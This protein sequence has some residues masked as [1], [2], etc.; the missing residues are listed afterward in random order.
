MVKFAVAGRWN[1]RQRLVGEPL[2]R[3]FPIR[4]FSVPVTL[5][6]PDGREKSIRLS[7]AG[8]FASISYDATDRSGPYEVELG[9]PLNRREWYA[10]NVDSRESDLTKVTEKE[11]QAL[12]G[13]EFVYHT[14]WQDFR[15]E[16]DVALSQR[17]GLTRWLLLAVLCLLFVEQLMAWRFFYGFLLLYV[18][19]AI[20]FV[21]PALQWNAVAGVLLMLVLLAGFAAIAVFGRQR[22][23]LPRPVSSTR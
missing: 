1:E 7:E 15:R 6:L 13:I 21:Q 14:H 22:A 11:L 2:T 17:G 5:T 23:D 4:A 12:P 8:N 9:P 19:V 20:G 3:A 16:T 10:V 18:V